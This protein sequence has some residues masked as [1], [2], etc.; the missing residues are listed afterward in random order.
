M[1]MVTIE[2]IYQARQKLKDIVHYTP[3]VS[4][5]TFSQICENQVFLKT[6][7]QQ[8][9]GSFKIR[10]AYNKIVNLSDDEKKQGVIAASAGN[11][12][13]GVALAASAYG[14]SSTIVM[15]ESTPLAKVIATKGYGANVLLHGA[16]YDEAY[17]KAM[18]I[19]KETGAT[20]IHPFDDTDVIAGQGTIGLEILEQV[21]EADI[22]IAPVGGGGLLAGLAVA[23][24]SINPKVKVIG[25]EA[26]TSNSMQ[27]SI[28]Q[29]KISTIQIQNSIADGIAVKT[30]GSITYE[31]ISKYVDDIVTV[32]ELEIANAILMLLE[33]TKMIVEG[34]G[35]VG[36]AAL[37]HHKILDKN[38]K[39]VSVVSGGNIDTHML[40]KIIHK[41]LVKAGRVAHITMILLDRPG[42]LLKIAEIMYRHRANVLSISHDRE[43]SDV[44][45]GY[46]KVELSLETQ[47]HEHIGLVIQ[48][49]IDRGYVVEME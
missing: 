9:T 11:H 4:S 27:F 20:F 14:I 18:E 5:K 45:L 23:I 7:N 8:R 47:N 35:A 15:P 25:V 29:K 49:L 41:G 6:E 21:S 39:I 36:V 2:E 19:Q 1:R 24:K 22:V 42:E 34:A 16:N 10:G 28:D 30:P 38:K 37:L 33:R 48:E 44:Q 26:E 32:S 12:A 3:C 31:I 46:A 43:K 40:A 13:Q 17:Q